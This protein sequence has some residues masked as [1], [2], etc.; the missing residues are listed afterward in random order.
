MED[1]TIY[2]TM[3]KMFTVRFGDIMI[4]GDDMKSDRLLRLF[5]YLL[6]NHE[7][8]IPSSE[9]VDM[10]WC[11]EEVDNPIG[12]LKNLVYRL[13]VLLKKTFSISDLITTGKGSYSINKDYH[14]EVDALN[15]E[16]ECQKEMNTIDEYEEFS[17][18]YTGKYLVE[19][20]DDH[21][22]ITKRTY[23]DSV[24]I[25]R[26]MEYA[27]LLEEQGEYA[28]MEHV[29]KRALEINQLEEEL[30]ELLIRSLCYQKQYK[31]AAEMYRKTTELLYKSLGVK[32][33]E[34]MQNLFEMIKKQSH[35]EDADIIEIQKDLAAET[36]EGAFL[37]E[38]GTFRE[39]Y[40]MHSRL[41]GRLGICAHMCL[42]SV[43]NRKPRDSEDDQKYVEKIMEK[44]QSA[45]LSGL[46][47]GD[48]LSRLSVNQ[49]IV[50]LPSCNYE[51]SS[52]V[53]NR[54]LRKIRYS[55]NHTR[56]DLEVTIE[57]VET[58]G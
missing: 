21:N 44:M 10:L 4:N 16:K 25:E 56:F 50:L 8:I 17:C 58:K 9:L 26:I 38:Y 35:S 57:E 23:Y 55:L 19:V 52:M 24:Y 40:N 47:I 22:V 33:S 54:V 6:Y 43:V 27:N 49:F 20:E 53:M 2:V 14:I 18:L 39:I 1:N 51:N 13:R 31:Q 34:S 5:A 48:V 37:C 45:M 12:A 28:K 42:V 15:F 41:M 32:P 3:F 11:F 46:R 30:Y 36:P 7:R 29:V